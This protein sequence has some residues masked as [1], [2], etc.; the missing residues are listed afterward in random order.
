MT[1]CRK[2]ASKNSRHQEQLQMIRLQPLPSLFQQLHRLRDVTDKRTIGD[3]R[4]LIC[5]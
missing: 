1:G 3:I 4:F 5:Q 2:N